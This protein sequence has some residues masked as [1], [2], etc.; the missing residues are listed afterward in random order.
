MLI[1]QDFQSSVYEIL[2]QDEGLRALQ[3]KPHLAPQKNLHNPFI[4]ISIVKVS[5]EQ[6]PYVNLFHISL[7]LKLF[8]Q[9]IAQ[10]SLMKGAQR[11]REVLTIGAFGVKEYMILGINSHETIWESGKDLRTTRLSLNYNVLIEE[12]RHG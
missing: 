12:A 1:I 7:Q 6:K 5:I 4:V 3:M 8:A 11:V 9:D 2:R 10:I